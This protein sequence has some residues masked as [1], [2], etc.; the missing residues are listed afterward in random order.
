MS[1]AR[2]EVVEDYLRL[3]RRD[4]TVVKHVGARNDVGNL[5]E[6]GRSARQNRY[7]KTEPE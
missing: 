1:E 6:G 5:E 4:P 7:D 2:V 3:V